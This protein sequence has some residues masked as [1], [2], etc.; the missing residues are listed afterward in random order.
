MDADFS[1]R[2]AKFRALEGRCGAWK[3][4][5]SVGATAARLQGPGPDLPDEVL[6]EAVMRLL[7]AQDE[8]GAF[9]DAPRGVQDIVGP[10]E[11]SRVSSH[12]RELQ[13]F[14]D[15]S[16]ADAAAPPLRVDQQAAQLRGARIV[17]VA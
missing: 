9:I 14:V 5:R 7:F 12:P 1:K 16:A 13:A 2:H 4:V 6:P 8:A 10:Q 15:E 11:H 17:L 3:R